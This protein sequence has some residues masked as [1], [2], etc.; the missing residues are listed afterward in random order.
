MGFS[1]VSPTGG[2]GIDYGSTDAYA[3]YWNMIRSRNTYNQAL[4]TFANYST[5]S[6]W[7]QF[8]DVNAQFDSE[9][10]MQYVAT[11]VNT[12]S[13][14][15]ELRGSNGL[16]PLTSG[17]MQMADA[18]YRDFVGTF[19]QNPVSSLKFLARYAAQDYTTNAGN[20]I[21]HDS[22]GNGNDLSNADNGAS[23]WPSISSTLVNGNKALTFTLRNC[24]YGYFTLNQPCEYVMVLAITNSSS[25]A[26][27]TGGAHKIAFQN[28][29]Q[30]YRL[31]AGSWASSSATSVTN[32]FF[33]LDTVFNG[34]SS[35]V[36]TNNAGVSYCDTGSGNSSEFVV[37]QNQQTSGDSDTTMNVL[38]IGI[39]S[40]QLSA[41]YRAVYYYYLASRYGLTN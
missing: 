22:S 33:V 26:Y 4:Q 8:I 19:Y 32:T 18:A 16:H 9:N 39:F 3:S 36:V 15:S 20:A 12:R 34:A 6:G 21:W 17:Y 31:N 38:E 1:G 5:N 11:N 10:N 29:G 41:L 23:Y 27:L 7:M 24:L 28:N 2:L 25:S 37:G 14:V 30:V 40:L 35:F 13:T